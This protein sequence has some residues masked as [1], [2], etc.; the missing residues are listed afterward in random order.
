MLLLAVPAGLFIGCASPGPPRAPSLRLPDPVRD[1]TVERFGER[2]Q[3]HWTV[4]TQSTDHEPLV[5]R[6]HSAGPLVAEL[7]RATLSHGR[8]NVVARLP[9]VAGQAASAQD[10]LPGPLIA[11]RLRPLFYSVRIVNGE[12]R[13][14]ESAREALTAAGEAPPAITGLTA[15]TSAQGLQVT[16]QPERVLPGERVL[17]QV[18]PAASTDP[19]TAPAD[20]KTPAKVRNL[21]VKLSADPGDA[22]AE[23]RTPQASLRDPG[24]A[25]DP[26]L[27]VGEQAR[28]TVL[29]TVS[30]TLAG[31][32]VVVNGGAATVTATRER[33][34]FPPAVPSGLA[35][36][37]VQLEDTPPEIDLSWEPD[38]EPDLLGYY[39]YRAPA[40]GGE[41]HRLNGNPVPAISFRDQQATVGMR[42][43]Y[44]VSAVDR[45]GNES[46]QSAAVEEGLRQP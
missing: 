2:V 21:R 18:E 4:P 37:A 6:K 45:S 17:L 10:V 28:Y 33:D 11:G 15:A 42:Y 41:F 23:P 39:L 3:L 24:G 27:A 22:D 32:T 44:T 16:W 19:K 30:R 34:T 20:P 9:V 40:A 7:C 36:L 5:G 31:Q 8:C 38:T 12:G 35:A 29:R 1:L 25:I 46:A 14:A 26:A 43:R 13:S